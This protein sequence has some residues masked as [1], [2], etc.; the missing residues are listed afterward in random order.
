MSTR[1]HMFTPPAV[2][3][4]FVLMCK[5]RNTLQLLLLLLATTPAWGSLGLDVMR[6]ADR[7]S[8]S[9]S[10]TSPA[11]STTSGNELL[12]VVVSS[13]TKSAGITVTGVSG[14]SLTCVLLRRTNIHLGTA[15][16]SRAFAAS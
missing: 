16:P 8:S 2:A 12:L 11:F 7:S 14:G 13:D 4:T 3:H 9:S 15:E 5:I 1:G 10:I 6:F